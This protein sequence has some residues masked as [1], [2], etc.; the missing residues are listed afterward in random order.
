MPETAPSLLLLIPAYN[1]AQR[2][3][4][5][6][7]AYAQHF[8]QHYPGKFNVVVVLNGCVD[9]TLA[10]VQQ[11]EAEF[12]EIGHREFPEPIGKGGALIEGLALAAR[13]DLVGFVDADGA[14]APAAFLDLVQQCDRADCVIG[15]R[16]VPGAVLRQ[17][18]PL[19]RRFFSRLFHLFVQVLFGMNI[20]DTQ[21]GAKV[22][23]SAAIQQIHPALRIAD[24]A[25][26]INLLYSLLRAGFTI[27]EAPTEWTDQAGSKVRIGRRT[28]AVP[29][30]LIRLR[31]V[32]SPF[33]RWLHPLRPLETWIYKTLRAPP[34]RPRTKPEK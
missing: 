6:L 2:I 20:R 5:V 13:A 16:W 22:M 8:R 31:L 23:R 24:L 32:Y 1:E 3:G 27:R 34:P 4:P 30:S 25:F 21:C 14:T 29:L 7:R 19:A 28:L 11:A 26:D 15:S 10:V 33:Y 18:Q 9:D 12:P 17:T